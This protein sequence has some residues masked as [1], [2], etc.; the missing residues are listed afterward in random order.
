V[1][2]RRTNDAPTSATSPHP[3]KP[4]RFLPLRNWWVRWRLV[5]V[6]V[7]VAVAFL[8][9]ASFGIGSS[10]RDVRALDQGRRLA[11]FGRQVT[12]LVHELQAERDLTAG[13]MGVRASNLKTRDVRDV[14]QGLTAQQPR[15]DQRVTAYREAEPRVSDT[16]GPGQ[17]AR[18]DAARAGLE[19]L[20][21]VRE[22]V[23][24]GSLTGE[25]IF[26][27]YSQL[28]GRLLDVN[29]EIAQPGGGEEL[30][31]SVRS[32]NDFSRVKE[33]TSQI[34]GSLH[35]ITYRGAFASGEFQVLAGLLGEQRAATEQFQADASEQ[36]RGLAAAVVTGQAVLA[37]D[38]R[39]RTAL[40]RQ[41]SPRL[42]IDPPPWLAASST[43]IELMRS[44]ESRLLDGVIGQSQDLSAAARRDALRDALLIALILAVALLAL[45][46]EKRQ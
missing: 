6:L 43:Q 9:Q 24:S 46:V 1:Q 14:V 10:L 4:G 15:V 23:A 38:R 17:Q 16:L 41:A 2:A 45:F 35:G 37:V 22:A 19:D 21:G 31:Q 40:H 27:E 29:L 36:Q 11:E 32:F 8:V 26:D 33:V 12:A 25:G 5:A 39:A 13:Y 28:I 42:E 7:I 18:F 20:G 44:V 34:R 30:T 3:S